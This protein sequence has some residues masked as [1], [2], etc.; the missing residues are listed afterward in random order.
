MALIY[1]A[2]PEAVRTSPGLVNSLR[3]YR[4]EALI[5]KMRL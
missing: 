2:I 3:W 4:Q 1:L 5:V